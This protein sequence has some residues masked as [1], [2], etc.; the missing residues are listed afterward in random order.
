M[1]DCLMITITNI[2]LKYIQ[3]SNNL[4]SKIFFSFEQVESL[5]ILLFY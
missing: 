3:V 5:T 2:S 1:K 4:I